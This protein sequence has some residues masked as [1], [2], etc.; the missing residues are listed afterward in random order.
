MSEG[1]SE[2]PMSI[3]SC[4]NMPA[5][6]AEQTNF[7]RAVTSP[8]LQFT[9][10]R[11]VPGQVDEPLFRAHEARYVFAGRF[12]RDKAVLDLACGTGIGTHYLLK[13]GALTC[14][15]LDID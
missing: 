9:G 14:L 6:A 4:S 15:G 2:E 5:D 13:A 8:T 1:Y 10:E 12:V 3:G 11:I 7:D